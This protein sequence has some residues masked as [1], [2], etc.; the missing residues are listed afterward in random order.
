MDS[1]RLTPAA[2]PEAAD[3]A[4][5]EGLGWPR[6]RPPRPPHPRPG[7]GGLPPGS[8]ER[9][10][11]SRPAGRTLTKSL[12]PGK[13]TP[14]TQPGRGPKGEQGLGAGAP[15]LNFPRLLVACSEGP[16]QRFPPSAHVFA[17]EWVFGRA[18]DSGIP[19]AGTAAPAPAAQCLGL[20]TRSAPR[21]SAVVTTRRD[22]QIPTWG[23]P[24]LGGLQK[25]LRSRDSGGELPAPES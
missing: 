15:N 11:Y 21:P 23:P 4:A 7:S 16:S 5:A 6:A 12:R 3:P 25:K 22:R 19:R 13:P 9:L 18:E 1:R 14:R 8:G 20:C 17:R 2:S 24:L 10:I